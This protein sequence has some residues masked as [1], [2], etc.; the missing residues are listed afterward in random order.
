MQEYIHN[1]GYA[2]VGSLKL[3][4]SFAKEP[5]NRD[6]VLQKRP[7]ILSIL[8]TV[9]TPYC[10]LR[11]RRSIMSRIEDKRRARCEG[12][13]CVCLC[14]FVCVCVCRFGGGGGRCRE[15]KN[16]REIGNV[17]CVFMTFAPDI[18]VVVGRDPCTCHLRCVRER[19]LCVSERVL[20]VRERVLCVRECV[21]TGPMTLCRP[22]SHRTTHCT[23]LQHT[24]SHGNTLQH[25]ATRY[26]AL[27]HSATQC[28]TLQHTTAQCNTLHHTAAQCNTLQHTTAQC[29][30]VQHTTAHCDTLHACK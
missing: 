13:H 7:I 24:A 11:L 6:Y 25:S 30:T 4:V 12:R 27:Q 18:E 8:L 1:S 15:I 10:N 14:V 9:A 20:C 26:N 28:H 29:N 2:L 22:K 3:Y 5:Y 21:L 19:V 17:F 16:R 23:T